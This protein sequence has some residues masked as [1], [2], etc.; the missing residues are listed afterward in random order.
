MLLICKNF[1]LQN[2][3]IQSNLKFQIEKLIEKY[4]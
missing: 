2:I 1:L 3:I 4:P